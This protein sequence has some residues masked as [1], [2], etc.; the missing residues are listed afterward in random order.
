MFKEKEIYKLIKCDDR[1]LFEYIII[2]KIINWQV[3]YITKA[4]PSRVI[5]DSMKYTTTIEELEEKLNRYYKYHSK[6]LF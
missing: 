5:I 3:T 1:C 6:R 2:D 4:N